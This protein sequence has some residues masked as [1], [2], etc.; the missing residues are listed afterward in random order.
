MN[1]ELLKIEEA[2]LFKLKKKA[3]GR[4]DIDLSQAVPGWSM[5]EEA[6]LYATKLLKEHRQNRLA[7][8]TTDPGLDRLRKIISEHINKRYSCKTH[9][10]DVIVT[11]GAN[12]AFYTVVATLFSPK[13]IVILAEPYYFNH[14]MTLNIHGVE[15]KTVRYDKE[16]IDIDPD[17]LRSLC[18]KEKNVKAIVLVNPS[19]PTGKVYSKEQID[20]IVSIAY[21]NDL[22]IISDE[23]YELF[24]DDMVSIAGYKEHKKK[25]IIGSFSKSFS[26]TGFRTGYIVNT[27]NITSQLLKAQDCQIICAPRISQEIAWFCMK[28]LSKKWLERKK[29]LLRKRENMIRSIKS[30]YFKVLSAGSFFAYVKGRDRCDKIVEILLDK[31]ILVAPGNMFESDLETKNIRISTGNVDED[32]LKKTI[33][34]MEKIN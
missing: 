11:A 25:V 7:F 3:A 24:S 13:D 5:P 4:F 9:V 31:G 8:Y 21:E 18:E 19:N 17:H 29:S 28:K 26:M 10:D 22:W 27:C 6:A 12:Q 34:I 16:T 2:P 32:T 1:K 33:K 30:D 23:T 15:V 20:E 14:M